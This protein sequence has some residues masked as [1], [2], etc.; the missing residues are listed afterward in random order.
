MKDIQNA[1][2]EQNTKILIELKRLKE[3]IDSIDSG[4]DQDKLK[5]EFFKIS[6][7]IKVDMS[8]CEGYTQGKINAVSLNLDALRL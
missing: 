5:A 3:V 1:I 7:N 4:A 8:R 6:Q 2:I